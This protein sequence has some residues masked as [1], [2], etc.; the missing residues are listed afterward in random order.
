MKRNGFTLIEV[1]MTTL[2]LS[3]LVI[4][5]GLVFRYFQDN[6]QRTKTMYDLAL[7]DYSAWQLVSRV[8]NK[9]FPWLIVDG[10]KYSFYF[11]GRQDGFTA[12]SHTSVQQPEFPAVYRLFREELANGQVRLV[13]EEAVLQDVQL[14]DASQQLPFTYRLTLFTAPASLQFEYF[15]WPNLQ[16]REKAQDPTSGL[17]FE[18]AAWY[19][20]YD[21]KTRQQHPLIIQLNI[22]AFSWPI[23]VHD[24]SQSL[25]QTRAD[26]EL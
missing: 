20:E 18:P 22:D 23:R 9:T 21:A 17:K 6:W 16:E 26:P 5:G 1:L 15:G 25:L 12:V 4:S 8:V 19:A 10:D 3:L 13:Y 14:S 11:L 24:T 7:A 2:V